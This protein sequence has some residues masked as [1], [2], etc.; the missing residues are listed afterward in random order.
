MRELKFRA[1]DKESKEMLFRFDINARTGRAGYY[2]QT[3]GNDAWDVKLE[4]RDLELMQYVGLK[5][6]NG[7]EIYECME[8]D[9]KYEVDWI[10]GKYVL[11]EIS[12]GDIID[13][14]YTKKYEVTRQY[15]KI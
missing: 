12:S 14:D 4:E 11:C 5:D 10:G 15:T 2:L 1:W 6:K 8:L 3:S 9:N 13:L 7:I